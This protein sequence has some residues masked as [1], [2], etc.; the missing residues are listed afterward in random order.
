MDSGTGKGGQRGGGGGGGGWR[1]KALERRK[2][3]FSS[4]TASCL[5]CGADVAV[6][7]QKCSACGSARAGAA[8][9]NTKAAEEA[10]RMREERLMNTKTKEQQQ[11]PHVQTAAARIPGMRRPVENR[12]LAGEIGASAAAAVRASGTAAQPGGGGGGGGGSGDDDGTNRGAADALRARLGGG[13]GGSGVNRGAADALR[14]RLG[15]GGSSGGG[16]DG[17]NRGAA[18]ALR[19]RLGGGGGGGTAQPSSTFSALAALAPKAND[20]QQQQQERTTMFDGPTVQDM[21]AEE[22]LG[23]ATGRGAFADADAAMAKHLGAKRRFAGVGG[24]DRDLQDDADAYAAEIE[25]GSDGRKK[26]QQKSA[27]TAAGSG[28]KPQFGAAARISKCPYCRT[29][30]A[31]DARLLLSESAHALLMVPPLAGPGCKDHMQII[32]RE[33]ENSLRTVSEDAETEVRNFKKSIIKY[34]LSKGYAGALF[35]ET[36]LLRGSGGG[37]GAGAAMTGL[38]DASK[39]LGRHGVLDAVP[40]PSAIEGDDGALDLVE[41]LMTRFRLEFTNAESEW[42]QNRKHACVDV[43]KGG[44]LRHVIPPN[45]AYVH[46]EANASKGGLLHVVEDVEE[47]PQSFALE[48]YGGVCGHDPNRWHAHATAERRAAARGAPPTQALL[49]TAANLRSSFSRFDWV[50]ATK[51]S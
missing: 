5:V 41:A 9:Q 30:P 8:K 48:V 44:G 17:T 43:V 11:P 31:F 6:D 32:P 16:G 35:I 4:N 19:A 49:A 27:G 34:Y 42:A 13:G 22:R 12:G 24:D 18:D 2:A 40:L 33:H 15:G 45:F 20:Q 39:L 37:G 21:M 25:D 38:G 46:V 29:S 50:E 47:W 26:K 28:G 7:A 51:E 1:S 3:L 14:A 10:A 23:K 36:A